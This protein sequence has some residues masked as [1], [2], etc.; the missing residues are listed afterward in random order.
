MPVLTAN[1]FMHGQPVGEN[2]ARNVVW[3]HPDGREMDAAAWTNPNAKVIGLF[4]SDGT[5]RLLLLANA[6]HDGVA[7]KLPGS[8]VAP[9]WRVR[10]DTAYGQID[11]PEWRFGADARVELEGRSLLLLAGEG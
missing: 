8:T 5:M 7:F 1:I 2:G 6:H 11:P 3:Y 10:V 9:R 4:R